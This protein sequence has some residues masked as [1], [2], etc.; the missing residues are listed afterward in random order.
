MHLHDQAAIQNP[1]Q[2]SGTLVMQ[3]KNVPLKQQLAALPCSSH[4]HSLGRTSVRHATSCAL[5]EQFQCASRA[6]CFTQT[7]GPQEKEGQGGG[8]KLNKAVIERLTGSSR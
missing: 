8:H 7:L 1:K 2:D 5:H 4:M 3:R 6:N